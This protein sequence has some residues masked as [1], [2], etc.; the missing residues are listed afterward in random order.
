MRE[1]ESSSRAHPAIERGAALFAL[2]IVLVRSAHPADLVVGALTVLAATWMSLRL[3]PPDLGRV[4]LGALAA[5]LPLFAWHSVRAGVDIAR[6]AFDPRLPLAP[7]FVTYETRC[8]R[9]LA[10]STFATITSLLPGTVPVA[11]DDR[12]LVYHCLDATQP[13]VEDLAAEERTYAPALVP[14]Q[15][16]A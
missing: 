14:G 9:G 10:R 16:R 13:V 6:R 2:W 3:L 5:R 15:S 11:D 12:G 8:P 1:T 7:G 4:R